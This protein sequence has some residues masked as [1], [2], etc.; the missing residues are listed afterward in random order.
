MFNQSES[1][2]TNERLLKLELMLGAI[3]EHLNIDFDFQAEMKKQ[4][5]ASVIEAIENGRKI[6]AIK[7]YR[8]E[9]GVGLAEA[10]RIIEMVSVNEI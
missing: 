10:Q 6:E 9:T 5:S 7:L 4:L 1:A 2:R 3:I 8:K